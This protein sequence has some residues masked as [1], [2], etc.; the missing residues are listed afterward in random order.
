MPLDER[1]RQVPLGAGDRDAVALE[2]DGARVRCAERLPLEGQAAEELGE[3]LDG[4]R[5]ATT[6]KAKG[7]QRGHAHSVYRL[8]E[9]KVKRV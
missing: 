2:S 4:L 7:P 6:P 3:H 1:V 8:P 5:H 9:G